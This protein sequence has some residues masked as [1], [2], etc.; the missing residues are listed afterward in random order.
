MTARDSNG[1]RPSKPNG[2]VL[3]G[4]VPRRKVPAK[5][6]PKNSG[7]APDIARAW[8]GELDRQMEKDSS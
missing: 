5:K 7:H 8:R 4:Y 3:P 6:R 2:P 1:E